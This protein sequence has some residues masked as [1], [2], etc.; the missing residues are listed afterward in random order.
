[1]S[2]DT[3]DYAPASRRPIAA[4]F[5]RTAEPGVR[6][7]VAHNVHPDVISLTSVVAAALAGECFILSRRWPW[8]LLVAPM[9]CYVRLWLNMLDGMVALAAGK[10]SLTALGVIRCS[11]TGRRWGH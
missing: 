10:A 4:M 2:P 5:R 1:M 11:P 9:F 3:L 8:L 7:C 6:F